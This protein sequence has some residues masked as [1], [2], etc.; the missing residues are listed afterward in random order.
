MPEPKPTIGFIGLGRMGLPMAKKLLESGYPV[1]VYNRT[2]AKAAP[3]VALGAT[4]APSVG[5]VAA[6]ADLIGACLDRVET[7]IAVFLG[8]DGVADRARAG[9]LAVDH[10]TIGPDTARTIAQG[11]AGRGI[12]FLDAPVSGGPEGAERGTLTIMAGGSQ[13]GFDRA[14]PVLRAYG[15]TVVR[16]GGVGTGSLTKLVNQLLC[17]VHG[18]VAAE[19]LAFAERSGLD[20]AAVGRVMEVSFGQSRM[21]ERTL[22]RVLA[23]DLQAGAALRL[24]DKDLGLIE[25]VGRETGARLPLTRAAERLLEEALRSGLEDGDLAALIRLFRPT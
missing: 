8:P 7:S 23:G 19:A 4:L 16:M 15:K 12:D 1:T 11:L 20:L 18:A 3:L 13:A 9:T 5:A 25:Q 17:F 21:F 10:G 6:T 14:A 2:A 22:G 24:Y